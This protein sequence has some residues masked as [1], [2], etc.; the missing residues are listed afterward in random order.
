[1]VYI[2][3]II[4]IILLDYFSKQKVIDKIP[5]GEKREISKN[6]FLWH[7]KNEG[8]AY[9]RFSKHINYILISTGAILSTLVY[10]FLK[11][12]KDT[13]K[14]LKLSLALVIGGGL[15]N[16][17]DRLVNK[18]VTDF[19]YIKHKNA[20]IFNIADIFI[21]IGAVLCYIFSRIYYKK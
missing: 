5:V 12:P 8:V 6:I 18:K 9:G 13:K 20:P 14:F 1:M 4:I 21:F 11:I 17:F 2:F 19:I 7:V 15:G 3:I 10:I 16:F